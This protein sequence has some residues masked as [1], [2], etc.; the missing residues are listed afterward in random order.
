[1]FHRLTVRSPEGGAQGRW[2]AR[3]GANAYHI[4][5][6]YDAVGNRLTVIT[7]PGSNLT[8]NTY[9]N[10]RNLTVTN[11]N[12]NRTTY[13]W[14]YENRLQTVTLAGL[15]RDVANSKKAIFELIESCLCAPMT[16]G[17]N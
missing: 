16:P 7:D 11:A 6:T 8:T 10:N 5:Y 9:N 13:T 12:G 15:D 14:T 3:S 17:T 1:M 4:T 2:A